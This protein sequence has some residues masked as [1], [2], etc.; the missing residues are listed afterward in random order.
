MFIDSETQHPLGF[1]FNDIIETMIEAGD[2]I[3]E[4][5]QEG[6]IES[7]TKDDNSPL[8]RADIAS[9]KI[10]ESSLTRIAPE[11]PVI[12]E[13]QAFWSAI[14]LSVRPF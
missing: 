6:P 11:I 8:T 14:D 4:I 10:I 2:A 1:K 13:E 3:N 9:H 7:T 12:S 5:Y